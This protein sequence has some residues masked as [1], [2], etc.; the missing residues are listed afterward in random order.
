VGSDTDI[1]GNDKLGAGT[2]IVGN[3]RLGCDG[4]MV[5]NDMLDVLTLT[6]GELLD[7]AISPVAI[8][9]C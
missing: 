1:V 8:L 3:E 6:N 9:T 2:D 4:E 7:V 5:E